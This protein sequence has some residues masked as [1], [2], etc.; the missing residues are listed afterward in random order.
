ML[1]SLFGDL[2]EALGGVKNLQVTDPTTS[3]L[4]VRW[5]PAEGNV[6]QYRLFYVPASGGAE[7]MEQVSGGTTAT[8]LRNLLSD[9]PY[10]IT[11]VPVYPEG[12]GLRQSETGKTRTFS[13]EETQVIHFVFIG[14]K[15]CFFQL[16]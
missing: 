15:M 3:S 5:E 8:V 9:T 4:K 12:E 13:T 10:T 11:V 7:D 2:S 6:R 14:T 16:V 1:N